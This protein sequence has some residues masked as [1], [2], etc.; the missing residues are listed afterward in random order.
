[1][2]W[3]LKESYLQIATVKHARINGSL[4]TPA[5]EELHRSLFFS[6]IRTEKET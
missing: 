1:M 3:G 2:L 5:V 4:A 6:A